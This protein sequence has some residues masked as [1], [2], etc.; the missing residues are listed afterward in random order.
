MTRWQGAAQTGSRDY[1]DEDV[2]RVLDAL[3]RERRY[4][5][6]TRTFADMLQM[7]GRT[8]RAVLSTRDGVDFLLAYDGDLFWAAENYE[9]TIGH[10]EMLRARAM[11]ELQRVARR[12]LYARRMLPRLQPELIPS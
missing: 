4:A 1:T 6:T 8:V 7:D 9:Q 12:E 3:P 11:T 2:A 10:T 5:L